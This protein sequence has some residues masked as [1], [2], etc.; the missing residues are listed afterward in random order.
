MAAA[1]R[2]AARRIGGRALLRPRAEG[3]VEE[4]QRRLFSAGRSSDAKV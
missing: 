3:A 1:L 4:V 2:H